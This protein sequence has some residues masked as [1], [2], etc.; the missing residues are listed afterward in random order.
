MT[1]GQKDEAAQTIDFSLVGNFRHNP[2]TQLEVTQKKAFSFDA[3]F[4]SQG[5]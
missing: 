4:R 5:G 2:P 1:G 3:S